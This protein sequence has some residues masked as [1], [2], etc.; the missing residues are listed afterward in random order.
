MNGSVN[1]GEKENL[2]LQEIKEHFTINSEVSFGLGNK[3]NNKGNLNK[4]NVRIIN[5]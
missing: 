3:N 1:I 2:N 4:I 5:I